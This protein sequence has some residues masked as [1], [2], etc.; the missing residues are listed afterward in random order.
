MILLRTV[1]PEIIRT[2]FPAAIFI[3]AFLAVFIT[4]QWGE[5]DIE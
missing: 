2:A 5:R 4:L 3:L 1:D